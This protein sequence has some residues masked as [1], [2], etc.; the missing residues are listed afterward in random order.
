MYSTVIPCSAAFSSICDCKREN[1]HLPRHRFE[2]FPMYSS[3]I[4]SRY[5][6]MITE[7]SNWEAYPTARCEAFSISSSMAS[8]HRPHT[9]SVKRFNAHRG[10]NRSSALACFCRRCRTRPLSTNNGSTSISSQRAQ[11]IKSFDSPTSNPTGVT[12]SFVVEYE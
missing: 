1:S 9:R 6:R 4:P 3:V 12:S 7:F 8:L 10:L 11:R 2:Y 5:S